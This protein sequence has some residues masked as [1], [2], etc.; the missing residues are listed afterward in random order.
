MNIDFLMNRKNIPINEFG[1]FGG[2]SS[3]SFY[4]EKLILGVGTQPDVTPVFFFF[5]DLVPHSH[6]HAFLMIRI[7]W[8][9]IQI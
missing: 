2:Q 3:S 4:C 7:T 9:K 1:Y 5:N 8:L 6:T